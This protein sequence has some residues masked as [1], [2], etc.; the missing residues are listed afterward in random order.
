AIED[1]PDRY[2]SE[3]FLEQSIGCEKCHGPGG[4]HVA[5]H[6]GSSESATD[7]IVNPARLSPEMRDDVCLQCHLIGEHRLTRY[8]RSDFDFRPGDRLTDIWTIFVRANDGKNSPA[9]EAVSQAEQILSSV[10]YRQ[11]ER[12]M[13]CVSC[14]DPHTLPAPEKRV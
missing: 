1:A 9:T 3:P 11:S 7:V 4:T 13:G 12:A 8:G 10:C 14:H 2:Q 5:F 6:Q